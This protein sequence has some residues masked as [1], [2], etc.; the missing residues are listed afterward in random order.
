MVKNA[1]NLKIRTL[2]RQGRALGQHLTVLRARAE[3]NVLTMLHRPAR[4]LLG[5]LYLAIDNNWHPE[6]Q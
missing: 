5:G 1:L 3:Y 4:L 6:E 2:P